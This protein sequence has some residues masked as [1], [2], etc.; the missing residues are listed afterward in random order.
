MSHE[1]LVLWCGFGIG[2]VFGVAGQ[3]SGFCLTGGLREWLREADDRRIGAFALAVAVAI[4]G[5]QLIAGFGLVDLGGTIY[6]Q[7]GFSWLL[8][9]VGGITFGYGMALA[10]GCGSRALV[11]LASGNLRAL[12]VLLCLG[13][14][15]YVA[16]TGL[17]AP[18]RLAIADASTVSPVLPQPSLPGV[19]GTWGLDA[20]FGRGLAAGL[21][22]ALLA[23]FAFSRAG[24]RRAPGTA[25]DGV[26]IGVPVPAGW[27]VT[28]YLGAD[29]FDPVRVVSLTFVAPLGDTIQYLMFSTGMRLEFGVTTVAGVLAGA[30]AAAFLSGSFRLEAFAGPG[31]MLRAIAGGVL[32]GIGGALALGCSIGQGLSGLSTLALPS[33]LAAAGILAGAA[34]GVHGP[35]RVR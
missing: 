23:G 1:Q 11:L 7:S 35:L 20:A 33:F 3:R 15:A 28:G 19:F 17:L 24:L 27:F 22:A 10:N 29:D 6:L 34:A 12:L 2:M 18:L 16:L 14:S 4:A 32:M 21:V 25:L 31:S 13:V 9:P 30:A 26:L 5:T 8:L